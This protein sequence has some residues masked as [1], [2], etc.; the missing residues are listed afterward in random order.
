MAVDFSPGMIEVGRRRQAGVPNLEFVEADATALP[1]GDDEFDAVTISFGLRNVN[2]PKRALAEM[3][4]VLK[5]GGR[6]VI[7]EFSHP[8]AG[9]VRAGYDAYQRCVMP[10]L[11]KLSSSNHD[12]YSYLTESIDA[13]P[14]Q[15]TLASGSAGS[16]SRRVRVPQP[17][18]RR[19]RAAPRPQAVGLSGDR[20]PAGS[21]PRTSA[22]IR[23]Q[24]GRTP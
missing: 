12:A 23:A 9:F 15:S 21:T 20:A 19:R 10:P 24:V 17:H 13:W 16:G 14:D 8:P 5:P 4:R 1:F 18:R 3:Y 2:D 6:L 11:V 7:C 22:H